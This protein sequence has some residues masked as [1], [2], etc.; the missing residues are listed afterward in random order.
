MKV[1]TKMEVDVLAD[2]GCDI[3]D[4][5][6]SDKG[7]HS[8]PFGTLHARWGYRNRYDDEAYGVDL[9]ES[10]F[11]GALASLQENR[12]GALM[13][14]VSG[15]EHNLDFGRVQIYPSSWSNWLQGVGAIWPVEVA[16]SP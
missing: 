4:C 8:P 7:H 13:F 1:M 11:F 10:C 5:S 12:R 14:S 15:F 6:T 16:A 2:I 3:C 9:Y